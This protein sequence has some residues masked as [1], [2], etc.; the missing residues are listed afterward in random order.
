MEEV[1]VLM[2]L[3]MAGTANHGNPIITRMIMILRK[4]SMALGWG[5]ATRAYSVQ[6]YLFIATFMVTGAQTY[7]MS[8][9]DKSHDG[10]GRKTD[11]VR[12]VEKNY[13]ITTFMATSAQTCLMRTIYWSLDN[14]GRKA[15]PVRLGE[16]FVLS[17]PLWR[18][19]T[20]LYIE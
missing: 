3:L 1:D 6:V 7:S 8:T 17:R 4:V 16:S 15:N 10:M 20:R 2:N 18:P 14:T 5:T 9:I 12:I 19:V 11:F 13:F